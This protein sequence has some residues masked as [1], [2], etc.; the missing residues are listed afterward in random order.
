[1]STNNAIYKLINS[2][3]E[4]WN[5]KHYIVCIF[6]DIN[7]EFGCMS[8]EVLSSKL[9]QYRMTGIILNWFR[10]YLNDRWQRVFLECTATHSF[11][12]DWE[13]MKCGV[14]QDSP[15]GLNAV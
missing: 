1:M 14:P 3:Y 6:Y 12:S 11:Q 13:L 8:H 4:A 9:E 2:V 7:K 10:S 15:S 5:N